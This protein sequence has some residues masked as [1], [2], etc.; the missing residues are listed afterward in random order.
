MPE[1]TTTLANEHISRFPLNRS[2][3]DV[4]IAFMRH[5]G[6]VNAHRHPRTVRPF[7]VAVQLCQPDHL[8]LA[9]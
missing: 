5:L 3:D 7:R 6:E 9:E 4:F 1:G 8:A 2:V